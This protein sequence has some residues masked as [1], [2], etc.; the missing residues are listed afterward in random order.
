MINKIFHLHVLTSI[1]LITGSMI[2]CGS[3]NPTKQNT[4]PVDHLAF[5]ALLKKYVD[6][7]GNVDYKGFKN[8]R[9]LFDEYLLKLKRNPPNN[10]HWS[11]NEQLAYW[12]N[13]Y[14][15]F[16]IQLIIDNYPIETIKDIGSEIQL[17][18]IN[19]PW[20]IKFINI[21]GE[22][23]D[24]N[25]I[26]HNILRKNFNEPRIH[27]AIVCASF[28]CP[29]LR[30]EA[31]KAEILDQQL[32]D[33]T[34]QFLKDQTKNQITKNQIKIS[35]IF[36]WFKGDFTEKGTL[37]DFLNLYSPLKIDSKAKISHMDYDWS[38]NEQN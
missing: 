17:P 12:I 15:A 19:T 14:N 1:L 26:E 29:R 13:A 38:L 22:S 28:S 5:D 2:S 34:K 32:S 27:F 9:K 23:Y 35:K 25:N 10:E 37:I 30:R 6:A 3:L 8:D 24:L 4:V 7:K 11:K 36:S 18:F 20:D 21:G 33:Q 16:T 31:Y